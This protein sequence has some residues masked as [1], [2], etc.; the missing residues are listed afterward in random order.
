MIVQTGQ[1]AH[2]MRAQIDVLGEELLNELAEA[3]G[4]HQLADLVPKL[5]VF[6]DVLHVRR[7]AVEVGDEVVLER[8]L[9]LA[10][11]EV[12]QEEGRGVVE[13][14]AGSHP[15]RSVLIND[16]LAVEVLLHFTH[17]LIGRFQ[18]GIQAAEDGHWQDDIAVF[19]PDKDVA[20]GVIG[21]APDEVGDPGEVGLV[22]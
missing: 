13:S 7:E 8:L 16:S 11:L 14:L 5:E 2:G 12:T 1:L 22:H 20:Q 3:V 9:R 17:S 19:A 10:G 21:N 18:H 6:D 15:Q 4:L